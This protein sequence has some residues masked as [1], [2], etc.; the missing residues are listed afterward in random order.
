MKLIAQTGPC[1]GQE[2]PLTKSVVTIGRAAEND[3]AIRDMRLSRQHAQIRQQAQEWVIVDLGSTNGTYVNDKRIT[4]P[5][6]MR[7]GDRI[8]LGETTLIVQEHPEVERTGAEAPTAPHAPTRPAPAARPTAS[9]LPIIVAGGA[10]VLLIAVIII[11]LAGRGQPQLAPTPSPEPTSFA[12]PAPILTETPTPT[13]TAAPT[14]TATPTPTDTPTPSP[15][16]VLLVLEWEEPR[17]GPYDPEA[18]PVG[19]EITPTLMVTITVTITNLATETVESDVFPS[20][21]VTAD[22]K[23][24]RQV[25]T[26]M[27]PEMEEVPPQGKETRT[28]WVFVENPEEWIGKAILEWQGRRWEEQFEKPSQVT[29]NPPGRPMAVRSLLPPIG[30]AIMRST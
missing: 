13:A 29:W 27:P 14:T 24:F 4:G 25:V 23:Q 1:A 8:V 11:L 17:Y 7:P 15:T 5:Q 12:A 30:M 22:G 19:F 6:V 2:F 20:F 16:P 26:W 9:S 21:F 18:F 28:Y 10:T 3:V